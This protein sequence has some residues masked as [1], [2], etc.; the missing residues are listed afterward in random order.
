MRT[1]NQSVLVLIV[2]LGMVCYVGGAAA[3]IQVEGNP[4]L[5][6]ETLN[7]DNFN[8]T[9][10][11][12][13]LNA[14]RAT[15]ATQSLLRFHPAGVNTTI[16]QFKVVDNHGEIIL[17]DN[18]AGTPTSNIALKAVGDS[19]FRGGNFGIGTN[20][21]TSLLHVA[22]TAKCKILEITGGSDLAEHFN[23]TGD[24]TLEPGSVVCIDPANAGALMLSHE[25][26]DRKVAGIVSGA[27]DLGTGMTMSQEGHEMNGSC[28]VALTGRVYVKADAMSGP[29]APG[30][31]LT[32]SSTPG[33][34]M[35]VKDYTQAQG[36]IIG[37]AMTALDSGTGLVLVLVSLQ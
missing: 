32:T 10:T 9:I 20:A 34:A 21:P 15:S 8:C 2:A 12:P 23:V 29:I 4:N 33:H 27:G 1:F 30:D 14:I 16:A 19:Y 18:P 17:Q 28:P 31:L 25:S 6:T 22:G 36:A 11:E 37:K 5:Q 35:A 7:L 24:A 3:Q 13:K 26:Y